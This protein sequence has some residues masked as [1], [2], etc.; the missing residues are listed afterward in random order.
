M[1]YSFI[2]YSCIIQYLY[3]FCMRDIVFFAVKENFLSYFP[4]D[5]VVVKCL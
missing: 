1:V 5:I 4:I 3:M 2:L